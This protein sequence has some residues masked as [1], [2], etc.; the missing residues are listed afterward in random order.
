MSEPFLKKWHNEL[1]NKPSLVN[2]LPIVSCYPLVSLLN[3][4]HVKHVDLWI[5]DVEGAEM[6]VLSGT[7]F[8]QFQPSV[9]VMECDNKERDAVKINYLQSH[10]YTCIGAYRNC[11]CSHKNFQPSKSPIKK[12]YYNFPRNKIYEFNN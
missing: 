10:Q 9:I 3:L 1:Y 8:T 11:V 2:N 7:D 4:A 5:L 12:K 6:S